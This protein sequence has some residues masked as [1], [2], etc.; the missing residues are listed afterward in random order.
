MQRII[1]PQL[2]KQ[3]MTL[4]EVLVAMTILAIGITSVF[5]AITS[6]LRSS[7]AATGY[8]RAALLAQQA[9]SEF[10]RHD[11]LE[12]GNF[13]GTFD[14]AALS[15]YT[16]H[17]TVDSATA[18]GCYPVHIIVQWQNR[19][20]YTLDTVLFPQAVPTAPEASTAAA[21]P[22]SPTA[23]SSSTPEAP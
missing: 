2:H 6:C 13:D 12:A 16:W 9:A 10:A 20:T 3:G 5:N 14:D 15:A 21:T 19:G 22:P 8:S 23:N 18:E 7:D 4:L 17:A 11:T 1:S